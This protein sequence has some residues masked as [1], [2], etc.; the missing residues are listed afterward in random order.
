M[1]FIV[2]LTDLHLGAGGAAI[3]VDD[4][5]VNVIDD[6]ERTSRRD[7]A[8]TAIKK[9][10]KAFKA[11]GTS[12]SALVISG[13]V[14]V[15]CSS[16]GF[17]D[18]QTFLGDAF[19]DL[20]PEASKIVALPGNHDVQWFAS[21]AA[22]RYRSFNDYCVKA[23]FVTPPLE[24]LTLPEDMRGWNSSDQ[25]ALVNEEEH[26]AIVPINSAEFSGV[27]SVLLDDKKRELPDE[28]G[29]DAIEA[30]L[31]SDA[32]HSAIFKQLR[33]SREYDMA[34]VSKKQITAFDRTVERVEKRLTGASKPLLLAA[35]HHHLSPVDEREEIKPFESLSNL[36]RVRLML[37]EREVSMIFHGHKHK[38]RFF[39]DSREDA[40]ADGRSRNRHDM[41]VLAVARL[42]GLGLQRTPSPMSSILRRDPM[43]T[44]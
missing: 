13:D 39:W 26:W 23:G 16:E 6:G 2:H 17:A 28:S 38:S 4:R 5:K 43:A 15:T 27:R 44:T 10:M 19:G 36:G 31:R 37:Q 8:E 40:S 42:E 33:K 3:A 32:L 35:L 21:T 9:L 34:R 25:H 1:G 7:E 14:T 12:I 11:A 24:G 41:L 18:L 20:L 29:L 22:E 30:I